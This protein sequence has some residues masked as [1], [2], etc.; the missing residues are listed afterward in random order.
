MLLHYLKVAVRNLLKY[1]TQSIISMVGLAV[2]FACISLSAY[3]NYYE[4]TYDSFQPN[5]ERIYRVRNISPF[6][7]QISNVTPGPLAEYLADKYPEVL[8]VDR[9]NN[10]HLFGVRQNQ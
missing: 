1:K 5:A 6:T 3:W 8:R 2:G 4:V 7:H 9:N 10:K